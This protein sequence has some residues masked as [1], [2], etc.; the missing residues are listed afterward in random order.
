MR[1]YESI[2]EFELLSPLPLTFDDNICDTC[3]LALQQIVGFYRIVE[4]ETIMKVEIEFGKCRFQ[5]RFNISFGFS[6]TTQFQ[7]SL[8]SLQLDS[9]SYLIEISI[10]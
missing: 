2:L 9:F 4:I 5:V 6:C 8:T 1:V 3:I 7:Q 10:L